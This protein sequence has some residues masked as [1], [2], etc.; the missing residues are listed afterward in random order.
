MFKWF[1]TIFSLGAPASSQNRWFFHDDRL[2]LAA[3]YCLLSLDL[4]LEAVDDE[5]EDRSRRESTPRNKLR[6]WMKISRMKIEGVRDLR[7]LWF[8]HEQMNIK[9]TSA[10]T[11]INF[12]SFA[13]GVIG[14][15]SEYDS[16]NVLWVSDLISS[17]WPGLLWQ[18]WLFNSL[19]C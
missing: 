4:K 15:L 9:K 17:V 3:R 13:A 6:E 12:S 16:G 5:H 18:H 8:L 7:C 2:L 1:W 19:I 11:L 14:A 10:K